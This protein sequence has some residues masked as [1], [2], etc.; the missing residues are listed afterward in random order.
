MRRDA[1]QVGDAAE[2]DDMHARFRNIR[3]DVTLGLDHARRP[4]H[5]ILHVLGEKLRDNRAASRRGK[6]AFGDLAPVTADRE[7]LRLRIEP[8]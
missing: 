1:L 2:V 5:A 4:F 7:D 6:G 3:Q 8:A